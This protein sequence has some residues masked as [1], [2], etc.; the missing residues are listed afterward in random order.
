MRGC[1]S[2]TYVADLSGANSAYVMADVDTLIDGDD[3]Q[4][5]LTEMEF[6]GCNHADDEPIKIWAQECDSMD[7]VESL[8]K[9]QEEG[10][11]F[12]AHFLGERSSFRIMFWK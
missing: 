12:I 9:T 4:E 3:Y 6:V 8:E 10:N 2:P 1:A 11:L 7:A 5:P